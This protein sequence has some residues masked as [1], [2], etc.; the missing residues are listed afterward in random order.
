MFLTAC[1]H[2]EW[3]WRR[4]YKYNHSTFCDLVITG[5]V[6]LRP[7]R[8]GLLTVHPLADA[9]IT[10]FAVDNLLYHGYDLTIFWDTDGRR[11]KR[12]Q[13]LQIWCQGYLLVRSPVLRRV[14]VFL[15]DPITS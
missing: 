13:G 14:I 9:S 2:G 4:G 3:D 15:P 8:D 7:S 6:G 11:Y 10:Y 12:G 1:R 5:L